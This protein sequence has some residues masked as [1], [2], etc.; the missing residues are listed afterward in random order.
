MLDEINSAI[1]R[2]D[3]VCILTTGSLIGE[4]FDLPVLDTLKF[5]GDNFRIREVF[6]GKFFKWIT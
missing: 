4:G 5:V 1:A 3:P 6:F 2:K